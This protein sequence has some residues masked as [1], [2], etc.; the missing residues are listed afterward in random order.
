MPHSDRQMQTGTSTATAT[1]QEMN[2]GRMI[3][4]TEGQKKR[5]GWGG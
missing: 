3:S 5:G 2:A 1:A 4:C